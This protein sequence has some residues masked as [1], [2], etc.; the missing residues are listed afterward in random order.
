MTMTKTGE[1][2]VKKLRAKEHEHFVL[3]VFFKGFKGWLFILKGWKGTSRWNDRKKKKR[4]T[5]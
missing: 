3:L 1:K 4:K 5:F 2:E